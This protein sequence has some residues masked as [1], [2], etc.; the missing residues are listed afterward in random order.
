MTKFLILARPNA[1]QM[2]PEQGVA[3]YRAAKE[4]MNEQI[5]SG[6][7]ECHYTFPQGGGIAISNVDSHEELAD[8]IQSYP[9]FSFFDFEV[10]ALCDWGPIYDRIIKNYEKAVG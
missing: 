4:W 1:R 5:E 10:H 8:Q 7:V 6:V 3:L 9:L 2:T